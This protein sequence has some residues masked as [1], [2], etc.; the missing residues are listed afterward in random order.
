MHLPL[1]QSQNGKKLAKRDP[2][3]SIKNIID[4]DY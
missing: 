3:S 1:I 2:F 4:K